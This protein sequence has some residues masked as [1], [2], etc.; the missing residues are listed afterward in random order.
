[1]KTSLCGRKAKMVVGPSVLLGSRKAYPSDHQLN[2][3]TCG[4]FE[5]WSR[6][7]GAAWTIAVY[8]GSRE[9]ERKGI[10]ERYANREES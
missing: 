8:S 2:V 10:E 5:T 4:E 3:L 7:Q 1:M 6:T 9:S